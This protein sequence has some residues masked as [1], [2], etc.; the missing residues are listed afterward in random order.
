M[1]TKLPLV[2]SC[3]GSSSAAQMA[4]H[5]AV[6]L[7]RFKVAE[8]S[9]IAGVGGDVESLVRTAKSGRPVIALDGCPLH[10]V[11][12]ILKR[13]GLKPAKHYDLSQ[14]G[15]K[16][17]QHEDFC[18]KEAA[19]VLQR[20]LNDPELPRPAQSVSRQRPA[21]DTGEADDQ[22]RTYASPACSM[23]EVVD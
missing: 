5:V 4:N 12:R 8:M 2:Y 20:I 9:C 17:R 18:Q 10:C 7:D 16:K 22:P 13:H 19:A 21:A 15:I 1:S 23:P 14:L 6:K 11:A 3:S